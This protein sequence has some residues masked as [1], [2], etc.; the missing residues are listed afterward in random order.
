MASYFTTS[1]LPVARQNASRLQK[2]TLP[3]WM[4]NDCK[5]HHKN[6]TFKCLKIPAQKTNEKEITPI[7]YI[8]IYNLTHSQGSNAAK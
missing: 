1:T 2:R 4:H 8:V 6:Y 5:V 7:R 3:I